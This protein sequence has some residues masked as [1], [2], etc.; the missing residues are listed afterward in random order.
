[1]T[2]LMRPNPVRTTLPA[3]GFAYGTDISLLQQNLRAG[4]ARLRAGESR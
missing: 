1:M 4:L 2:A 3:G